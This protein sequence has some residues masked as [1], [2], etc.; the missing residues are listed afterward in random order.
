MCVRRSDC[1]TTS[2]EPTISPSP[3]T[4]TAT[5]TPMLPPPPPPSYNGSADNVTGTG[6]CFVPSGG[7][8]K[9]SSPTTR[10]EI[11][12]GCRLITV[13]DLGGPNI[14]TCIERDCG[15]TTPRP[16][17]PKNT[18]IVSDCRVPAAGCASRSIRANC[19]IF[20]GCDYLTGKCLESAECLGRTSASPTHQPTPRPT[21]CYSLPPSQNCNELQ[22]IASCTN[23]KCC[24]WRGTDNRC[25]FSAPPTSSSPTLSPTTSSSPS[26]APSVRKP[27]SCPSLW[28]KPVQC[29]Q[30]ADCVFVPRAVPRHRCQRVKVG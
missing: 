8:A 5:Q 28:S 6:P 12:S 29:R 27:P 9:V 1:V 23:F 19:I 7:C 25:V 2:V 4:S 16:S 30:R 3:S 13:G 11:Y 17:A 22:T 26:R 15:S 24:V 14:T 18:T 20:P 21:R 10:C